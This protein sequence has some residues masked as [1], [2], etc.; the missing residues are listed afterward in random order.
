MQKQKPVDSKKVVYDTLSMSGN[1]LTITDLVNQTGLGKR[2]IRRILTD[3]D[4]KGHLVKG[5]AGWSDMRKVRY[6]IRAA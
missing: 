5:L 3:I 6:K 2:N 4:G 1:G